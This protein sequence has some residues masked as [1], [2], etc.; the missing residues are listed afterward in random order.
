MLY[1]HE[2]YYAWNLIGTESLLNAKNCIELDS[3]AFENIFFKL[4]LPVCFSSHFAKC[5]SG[6]LGCV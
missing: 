6:G 3:R 5:N 1:L 2:A 4:A